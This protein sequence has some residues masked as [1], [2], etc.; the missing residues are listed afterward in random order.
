M[1]FS[2]ACS[3]FPNKSKGGGNALPADFNLYDLS[4]FSIQYPKDWEVID[5]FSDKYPKE[6]ILA[7]KN[8][9]ANSS[10]YA[11]V[12]VSKM[13]IDSALSSLDFANKKIEN[14]KIALGEFTEISRQDI[15]LNINGKPEKTI[16][17]LFS[18]KY[19]PQ[20]KTYKY[21]QTYAVKNN[22]AFT[23]TGSV[24]RSEKDEIVKKI[25]TMLKSFSLK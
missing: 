20:G 10:F 21:L 3:L 13:K 11:N 5:T 9:E 8:P 2:T 7:F 14:H 6:T 12:N 15:N 18:G 19:D 24:S 17:L 22:Y 25:E 16:L 4:D 1:L 23:I